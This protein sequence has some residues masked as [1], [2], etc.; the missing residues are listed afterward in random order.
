RHQL[1]MSSYDRLFPNQDTLPRGGLGN[2]IALPLQ[3]EPRQH[4]N[5]VF[6]NDRLVPHTDQWAYLAALRRIPSSTAEAIA[7]EGTTR[8]QIIGLRI[9]QTS[10]DGDEVPWEAPPSRR[11]RPRSIK[12]SLPGEVRAVL[13]QRVFV[14]K[15]RLPSALLNQIKRLAAFQNPEFYRRQKAR[16]STALTPRVIACAEDLP[17][18]LALPRGCRNGLTE[19]LGGH[20]ATPR[21]AYRR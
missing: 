14:E 18:H 7:E 5:T 17:Q 10:E 20:G 15:A 6:V 4:G 13:A 9:A 21:V 16:L 2:L 12:E 8:G 3:H 19:L 1:A 11:S